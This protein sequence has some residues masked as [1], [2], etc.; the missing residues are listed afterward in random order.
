M[1]ENPTLPTLCKNNVIY[2]ISNVVLTSVFDIGPISWPYMNV[3]NLS[4][5]MF[6]PKSFVDEP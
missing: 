4:T 3:H 6:F 1:G 5:G 2:T